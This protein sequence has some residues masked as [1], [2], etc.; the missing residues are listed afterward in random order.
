MD[1]LDIGIECGPDEVWYDITT[2]KRP[3]ERRDE[4]IPPDEKL[5]AIFWEPTAKTPTKEARRHSTP[6]A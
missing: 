1:L 4:L 6:R 2:R 5:N 3:M